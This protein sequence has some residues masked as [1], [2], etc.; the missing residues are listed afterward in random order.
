MG[1]AESVGGG[2]E[3]GGTLMHIP[4][5]FVYERHSLANHGGKI[6]C[7]LAPAWARLHRHNPP[8]CGDIRG[9][10]APALRRRVLGA[11]DAIVY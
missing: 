1:E 8:S 7:L 6:S 5:P 10:A 9:T 3:E 11:R 2:R 4:F